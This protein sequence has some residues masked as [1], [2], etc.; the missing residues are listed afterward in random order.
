MKECKLCKVEKEECEFGKCNKTKS[1]LT[2]RCKKCIRI[3]SKKY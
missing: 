2:A 1:G 3:E